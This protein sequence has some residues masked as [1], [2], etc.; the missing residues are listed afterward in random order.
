MLFTIFQTETNF[1]PDTNILE[2]ENLNSWPN[3]LKVYYF[4]YDDD[5]HFFKEFNEIS[6][7]NFSQ[8]QTFLNWCEKSDIIVS[9]HAEFHYKMICV[10]LMRLIKKG[11]KEFEDELK[12]FKYYK[13]FYCTM[14]PIIKQMN[15]SIYD[16]HE[17]LFKIKPRIAK[18]KINEILFCFRCFYKLKF[19]K[20]ICDN[21]STY[22]V[23]LFPSLKL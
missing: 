3:I 11:N 13:K 9:H 16:L 17:A 7:Y 18:N 10:E 20:D 12:K 22:Y 14:K 8:F 1:Y 23:L 2:N 19:D 5:L 4:V 15:P 6:V 21:N